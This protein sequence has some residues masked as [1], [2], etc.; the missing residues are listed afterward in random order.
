MVNYDGGGASR[1]GVWDFPRGTLSDYSMTGNGSAFP[2]YAESDIND[3]EHGGALELDPD[4]SVLDP[5][6]VR[7]EILEGGLY[8]AVTY[9]I[10]GGSD[11]REESVITYPS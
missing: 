3:M 5:P 2:L 10:G 6:G 11:A 1:V 9:T 8:M 7:S 4:I